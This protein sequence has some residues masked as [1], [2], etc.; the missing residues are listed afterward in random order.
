MSTKDWE[1]S[2]WLERDRLILVKSLLKP[3]R[4][5]GREGRKI[6]RVR[7]RVSRGREWRKR[8]KE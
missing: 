8:H 6:H 3:Q 2:D 7:E 4:E 1:R 5:G